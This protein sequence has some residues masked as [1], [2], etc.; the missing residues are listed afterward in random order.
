MRSVK[1]TIFLYQPMN[2]F[3]HGQTCIKL[4]DSDFTLLVDP[5]DNSTGLRQPRYNANLV[6][7]TSRDPAKD[8][9]KKV[10]GDP[11]IVTGPGEYESGGTFVYGVASPVKDN[12][13][14]TTTMYRFEREGIT[15]A[16]LGELLEKL[17]EDKLEYLEGVDVLMLPVGGHG[18][19]NAE[20]ASKLIAEIEPRLIIP[21]RYKIPGLK[22]KLDPLSDFIKV[23]GVKSAEGQD[24]IKIIKKELPQD[25][26]KVIILNKV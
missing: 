19:L 10:A 5:F 17:P 22:A 8:K 13:P 4:V 6:L 7:I 25:E 24:K 16:H 12:N 18:A 20:Q 3:W 26:T 23:M 2:L 1:T 11:F 9:S 14:V 21:L 15:F